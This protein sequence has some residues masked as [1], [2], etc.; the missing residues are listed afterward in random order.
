MRRKI[1]G[2]THSISSSSKSGSSRDGLHDCTKEERVDMN[3]IDVHSAYGTAFRRNIS[4]Y[5]CRLRLLGSR[6]PTNQY[7]LINA[8]FSGLSRRAFVETQ[9]S[10]NA[11]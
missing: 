8:T 3:M 4:A 11:T 5:M 1:K 2:S 9:L 7:D 6:E 10:C